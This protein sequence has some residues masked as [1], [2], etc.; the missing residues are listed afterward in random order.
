MGLTN[1][2]VQF[3]HPI[4]QSLATMEIDL[5]DITQVKCKLYASNNATNNN[6]NTNNNSNISLNSIC[7]DDYITK[8]MQK[9]L[10][11]PVTMRSII[12]RCK[13]AQ[14]K[15]KENLS[16]KEKPPNSLSIASSTNVANGTVTTSTF[17]DTFY[18]NTQQQQP[19]SSKS[20][21]QTQSKPLF[22]G[23]K[24]ESS[25][26][27]SNNITN[28]ITTEQQQPTTPQSASPQ[29]NL[30]YFLF[31][32]QQQQ[33]NISKN[34]NIIQQKQFLNK[35]QQSS[36]SS[37]S[38]SS[39][40]PSSNASIIKTSSNNTMLMSMLSDVPALGLSPSSGNLSK[41]GNVKK[42]KRQNTENSSGSD[43]MGDLPIANKQRKT[44]LLDDKHQQIKQEPMD[45]YSL[46]GSNSSLDNSD[47]NEHYSVKSGGD[48][49]NEQ[50]KIIKS[51]EEI[52]GQ[53]DNNTTTSSSTST[54]SSSDVPKLILKNEKFSNVKLTGSMISILIL[55]VCSN[56][57]FKYL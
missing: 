17:R 23:F 46:P 47:N 32:Q 45:E 29:K 30:Q 7:N 26:G 19:N 11:I 24:T 52:S 28:T 13:E 33:Q 18:Q 36:S 35:Y 22:S 43:Q 55:N 57:N 12:N 15:L 1:I 27:S 3:E 20:N 10:S 4:E 37:P 25:N 5:K 16:E 34:S 44:I 51:L 53:K 56:I 49:F 39:S 40:S 50:L 38:S 48:G 42:R 6:N 14:A 31:Q 2:Y 9:S 8:V 41:P 21:A 54:L